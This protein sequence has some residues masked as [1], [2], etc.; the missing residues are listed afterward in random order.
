[1]ISFIFPE[2]TSRFLKMEGQPCV[3]YYHE[4]ESFH[5]A[6]EKCNTDNECE[7]FYSN[8]FDEEGT[9]RLCQNQTDVSNSTSKTWT[10]RKKGTFNIIYGW[11]HLSINYPRIITYSIFNSQCLL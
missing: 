1:M 4:E 10:Y 6:A 7:M 11:Y 8:S 5:T 2:D 9:F 3:N